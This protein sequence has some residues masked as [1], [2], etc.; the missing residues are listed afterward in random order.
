MY[1]DIIISNHS[2]FFLLILIILFALS[3]TFAHDNKDTNKNENSMFLLGICGI[4]YPRK[5]FL[6]PMMYRSVHTRLARIMMITIMNHLTSARKNRFHRTA[7]GCIKDTN[8]F[9]FDRSGR[10]TRILR[11]LR[12]K[13]HKCL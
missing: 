7:H 11:S 8:A 12:M 2:P 3:L 10:L 9:L 1:S 13:I 5:S 4:D 6:Y